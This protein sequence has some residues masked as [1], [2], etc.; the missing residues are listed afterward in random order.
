MM[1]SSEGL[2]GLRVL[3]SL[4]TDDSVLED[5]DCS[6]DDSLDV[7]VVL[8]VML[9]VTFSSVTMA[10][11]VTG[12]GVGVSQVHVSSQKPHMSGM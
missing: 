3:D 2:K 12:R 9:V 7:A 10:A 6:D 11:C 1:N 8:P 5:R 4:I